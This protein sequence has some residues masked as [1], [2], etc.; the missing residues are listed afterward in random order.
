[1]DQPVPPEKLRCPDCGAEHVHPGAG[2]F[3]CPGCGLHF[4]VSEQGFA[5]PLRWGRHERTP[6]SA[7]VTVLAYALL[8]GWSYALVLALVAYGTFLRLPAETIDPVRHEIVVALRD[9]PLCGW[10]PPGWIWRDDGRWL[11]HT[12][13]LAPAVLA[14]LGL[15]NAVGLLYRHN[16]AWRLTVTGFALAALANLL[17]LGSGG[18]F[19]LAAGALAHEPPLPFLCA[20]IALL[21]LAHAVADVLILIRLL[22]ASA[23]REFA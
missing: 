10:Y 22:R 4:Q 8:V 6:H 3:I 1:M 18:R 21:L 5:R 17:L 19:A 14:G 9:R 16:R 20:C 15:W 11:A 23:R 2:L 13:L 7:F 12:L